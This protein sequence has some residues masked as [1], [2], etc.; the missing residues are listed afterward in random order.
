MPG[1][2]VE[3]KFTIFS[4]VN[5][6]GMQ[7][8]PQE[9]RHALNQGKVTK[10]LAELARHPVFRR[11]TKGVVE[12]SRMGDRELIARV[13][14]FMHLGLDEYKKFNELDGFLVHAMAAMNNC[15]EAVL[16]DLHSNFLINVQKTD[17]VFGRYA[18]RKMYSTNGRRSP[19]NKAL[20][21]VWNVAVDPYSI[22]DLVAAK[23]ELINQYVELT[24]TSDAFSRSISS[25]T[26]SY[27]A[28]STRFNSINELLKKVLNA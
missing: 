7:L 8:T 28:V 21:E 2:P 4:R 13:L 24:N 26:S 22:E 14:S 1:T 11:A 6:G 20:F 25:S 27:A 18:Y 10:L 3:A 9:I 12:S 16:K 5:T 19:F 23:D 17:A 15:K